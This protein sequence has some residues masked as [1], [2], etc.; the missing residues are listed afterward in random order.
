MDF[1]LLNTTLTWPLHQA[2]EADGE[3]ERKAPEWRKFQEVHHQT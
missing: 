1:L 2:A 3:A